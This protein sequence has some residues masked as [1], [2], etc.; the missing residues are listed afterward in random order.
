MEHIISHKR[1]LNNPQMGNIFNQNTT[2]EKTIPIENILA[3]NINLLMLNREEINT[4]DKLAKKSGIGKGTIERIKKAQVSTTVR[5]VEALAD[6]VGLLPTELI[7]KLDPFGR[8]IAGQLHDCKEIDQVIKIMEGLD[9]AG[10]LKCLIAAMDAAKTHLAWL[11]SLPKPAEE[12]H[13]DII[14]REAAINME[15]LNEHLEK[16]NDARK[17]ALLENIPAVKG[18]IR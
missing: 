8:K 10:K 11:N 6:A 9:E 4:I 5:T 13:L 7:T 1:D 2:M 16:V 18:K 15:Q 12:N 17:N 14:R 3:E